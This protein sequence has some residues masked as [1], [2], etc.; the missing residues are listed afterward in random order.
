MISTPASRAL[1]RRRRRIARQRTPGLLTS[2]GLL[3]SAA[4]WLAAADGQDLTRAI[5]RL[6]ADDFT[7]RHDASD[8]LLRAGEAALPLLR[9]AASDSDPEIRYRATDLLLHIERQLLLQ[10][11]A[12]IQSGAPVAGD[13]PVWDRF[14][15]HLGQE[16][17]GRQLLVAMLNSRPQL[18]LSIGDSNAQERFDQ[19][20]ADLQNPI[21][22]TSGQSPSLGE[23]AALLFAIAQPECHP[24]PVD[25]ALLSTHVS[26]P[27]FRNAV[28]GSEVGPSLRSLLVAWIIREETGSPQHRL[29]VAERHDLP[30][31][32]VPAREML[33][34]MQQG[35]DLQSA[36]H[37][38][39]RFAGPEHL[40]E[41]EPLLENA[42][43]L[44]S[45]G[46]S[47]GTFTTQV[48]D[49]ALATVW[50]IVRQNPA[51]HGLT[52]YAEVGGKPKPGSIGFRSEDARERALNAWSS[53]RKRNVKSHLPGDGAAVEGFS[54]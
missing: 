35:Q 10:R 2:L 5:R 15:L 32:L 34:D 14:T 41:I 17:C 25:T 19:A 9:D 48:R 13:L 44:T 36:L 46:G 23:L 6:G 20:I 7:L 4:T 54:L 8:E 52:G 45:T 29:Q 30:E 50:R 26:S 43:E 31:G 51:A 49:V 38:T 47:G 24:S 12:E 37:F 40:P 53:W 22:R 28:S 3:L 39:A 21:R 18:M 1:G 33:R 11:I 42:Q 16:R 27:A